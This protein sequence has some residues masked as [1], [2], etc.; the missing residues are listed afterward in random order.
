MPN[1]I[2]KE[3]IT[4]SDNLNRISLGAEVLF[5]RLIVYVDDYGRGHADPKVIFGKC[6]PMKIG[7]ITLEQVC[8]WLDELEQYNLIQR[9]TVGGK[10]YLCLTSWE[11]HQRIRNSVAKHPS[12]AEADDD[13]SGDPPQLAATRRNSPQLAADCGLNPIQSNPIRIQ[14]ESRCVSCGYMCVHSPGSPKNRQHPGA[15]DT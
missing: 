11:E 7:E 8:G 5:Y 15:G 3:S 12:P 14:S 6:L 13:L 10:P 9:Y 4:T 1:R 2:I